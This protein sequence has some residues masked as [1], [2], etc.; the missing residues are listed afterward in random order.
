MSKKNPSKTLSF[1]LGTAFAAGMAASNVAGA[2]E[3][4]TNPFAMSELSSG[5]MQLADND[6]EGKCGAGKSSKKEEQEGKCGEG[7]TTKKEAQEGKCG[8]GKCGAD[9]NMEDKSKK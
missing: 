4:G 7:K 6:M 3:T 1:A 5:Y 8:E 9:M 2:A